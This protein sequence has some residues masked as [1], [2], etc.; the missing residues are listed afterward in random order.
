MHGETLTVELPEPLA[1]EVDALVEQGYPDR[2]SVVRE[3]IRR[4]CERREE[5]PPEAEAE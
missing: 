1:A 4:G 5:E 3:A 2:A